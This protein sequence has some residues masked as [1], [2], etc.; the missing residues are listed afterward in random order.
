ML[1]DTEVEGLNRFLQS[2]LAPVTIHG[3][4]TGVLSA[5]EGMG[6]PDLV[7]TALQHVAETR[8]AA[9]CDT[10]VLS[11][12]LIAGAGPNRIGVIRAGPG[13]AFPQSLARS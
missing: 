4:H 6:A 5:N 1:G 10:K 8:Q 9:L 13:A 3:P 12:G 11:P 7:H 2:V